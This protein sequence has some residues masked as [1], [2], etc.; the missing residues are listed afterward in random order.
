MQN[1]PGG[2]AEVD[3][4]EQRLVTAARALLGLV[5]AGSSRWTSPDHWRGVCVAVDHTGDEQLINIA[6]AG[7]VDP[8]TELV[9][10]ADLKQQLERRIAEILR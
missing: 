1:V 7:C 8:G 6:A 10:Y 3:E 4:S 2:I 9:A 5:G